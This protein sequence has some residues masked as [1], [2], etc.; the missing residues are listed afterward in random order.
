MAAQHS[1]KYISYLRVSTDRQGKSG[2]GRDAQREAI[3]AFLNG[4]DWQLVGEFEEHESGRRRDRPK[5]AA[6]LAQ[7]RRDNA[8]LIVARV[9]RIS[10]DRDFLMELRR[11][12][13]PVR[14]ANLPELS[15]HPLIADLVLFMLATVAQMEA[16][17]IS[18]NTK[19]ALVAAK[20][21][22]RKLGSSLPANREHSLAARQKIA[23]DFARAMMEELAGY[24]ARDMSQREIVAKLNATNAP[25][26]RK[27]ARWH[28]STLQNVMSRI[29]T[30]RTPPPQKRGRGRPRKTLPPTSM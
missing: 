7:C 18:R 20:A 25:T 10:R 24:V 9:D 19:A 1:G 27:G 11:G 12:D 30:I 17:N 6:A 29:E 4:G 3:N 15:D 23:D 14:F 5:L 28:L 22:G 8:T 13:V 26:P 2:L 16:E 21:R